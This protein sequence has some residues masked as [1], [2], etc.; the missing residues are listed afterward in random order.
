MTD[1]RKQLEQELRD[2]QQA[3][4]SLDN[5]EYKA[6]RANR[7]FDK[8]RHALTGVSGNGAKHIY[9]NGMGRVIIDGVLF[10]DCE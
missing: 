6:Y 9:K 4:I 7:Y 10:E 8:I 3:N 5:T 1:T 2:L